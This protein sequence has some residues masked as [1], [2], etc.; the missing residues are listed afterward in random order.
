MQLQW[1]FK[2]WRDILVLLSFG[3]LVSILLSLDSAGCV[4]LSSPTYPCLL[5][6]PEPLDDNLLAHTKPLGLDSPHENSSH[7]YLQAAMPAWTG[8]PS[9]RQDT[10]LALA[11]D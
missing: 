6:S 4:W 7:Q 3:S 8:S 2:D 11:K 1:D 5:P 10:C 9:M